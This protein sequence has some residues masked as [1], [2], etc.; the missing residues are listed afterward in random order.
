MG[1][2]RP[3]LDWGPYSLCGR[4][5]WEHSTQTPK[6][7]GGIVFSSATQGQ[8]AAERAMEATEPFSYVD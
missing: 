3:R 1:L 4:K 5:S 6:E 7:H 2:V 8:T